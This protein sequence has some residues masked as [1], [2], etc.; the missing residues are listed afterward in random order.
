MRSILTQDI[1]ECDNFSM[2]TWPVNEDR[3]NNFSPIVL[4]HPISASFLSCLCLYLIFSSLIF[5]P[6]GRCQYINEHCET[7]CCNDHNVTT[8]IFCCIPEKKVFMLRVTELRILRDPVYL[9]IYT[10]LSLAQIILMTWN[11][12][13][14]LRKMVLT[15][16]RAGERMTV[17]FWTKHSMV[18]VCY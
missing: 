14:V 7:S 17:N 16:S 12:F 3:E 1:N 8:N 18:V 9:F 13:S 11:A 4:P 15:A 2:R 10:I 6:L 5:T